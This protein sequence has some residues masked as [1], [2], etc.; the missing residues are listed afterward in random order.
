MGKAEDALQD[1][2]E[3]IKKEPGWIKG[4]HRKACAHRALG[5]EAL[6]L[7]AYQQ[8][9]KVDPDNKW[10]VEQVRQVEEKIVGDSKEKPLQSIEA[11]LTVFSCVPDSRERLCTLAHFWNHCGVDER[12]QI[13]GRFLS[14]IAG[15]GGNKTHT[16]HTGV[17]HEDF[18]SEMMVS[19]PMEN[20]QDLKAGGS[21]ALPRPTRGRVLT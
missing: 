7:A 11:W 15:E 10:L 6:A 21:I 14:L 13:F 8:A 5:Q 17:K 19:L 20:Y 9:K 12:Y 18:G 4:Y 16:A 1:A 3:A 2:E